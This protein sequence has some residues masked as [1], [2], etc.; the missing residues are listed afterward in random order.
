MNDK[1]GDKNVTIYEGIDDIDP[2]SIGIKRLHHQDTSDL[3]KID[4]L[5]TKKEEVDAVSSDTF[6]ESDIP[7]DRNIDP[8]YA[9][10]FKDPHETRMVENE[11]YVSWD[12]QS[13]EIGVEEH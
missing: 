4:Y 6:V 10:P 7:S 3:K 13:F 12:G 5:D 11:I 2:Y 9:Q 1:R 8:V